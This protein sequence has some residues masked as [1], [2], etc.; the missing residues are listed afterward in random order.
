MYFGTVWMVWAP[1]KVLVTLFPYIFHIKTKLNTV[2][3]NLKTK[4]ISRDTNI[5]PSM[6]W[7]SNSFGHSVTIIG[8]FW[9]SLKLSNP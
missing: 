4:I 1:K 3:K 6:H 7:T 5:P 8:G 9:A 2:Y